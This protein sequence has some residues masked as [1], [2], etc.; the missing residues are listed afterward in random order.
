MKNTI[1]T[2]LFLL[3]SSSWVYG[4]L[5]PL[6]TQYFNNRYL[7]NAA[8]AG[9]G[10]GLNINMNYRRQWSNVPGSP[11]LQ[12][13]AL[14]Y[15]LKKAGLGLNINIDKAGLQRL[16]RVVGSYAYHLQLNKGGQELSFGV[17]L[18][19][20]DQRLSSSDI[21]GNPNDP[22][23]ARYNDREG[24]LDGDFGIAYTTGRLNM[25]AS[26]PNLNFLFK[27]SVIRTSDIPTFYTAVS[28]KL[29]VAGGLDDMAIEPRV[30]FRGVK[31]FDN[32]LDV[33]ANVSF[34]NEQVMLMGMYHSS[35]SAS[36]GVGVDFKKRYLLSG[37]Y[38]TQTS[39][40][41]SYT[42]GSFEISLQLKV[43]K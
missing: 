14:D 33:G 41:S 20:M 15:G 19:Y 32:I 4:Q 23:A 6:S 17:S 3:L 9:A 2:L 26:L 16:T 21:L 42:N 7:G 28:Y 1:Y 22:L 5:N 31:G 30:A 25:E 37:S 18:G 35:K 13:L 12:N 43:G 36:F 39:E 29:M 24:Y 11:E 40:L 38:T 10:E 27:R 34:A 8:Y